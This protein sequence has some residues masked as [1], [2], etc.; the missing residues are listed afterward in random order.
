MVATARVRLRAID[1]DA[2]TDASTPYLVG[3]TQLVAAVVLQ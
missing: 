1:F 3:T 2:R